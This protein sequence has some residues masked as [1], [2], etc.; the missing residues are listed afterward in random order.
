MAPP[1]GNKGR[2]RTRITCAREAVAAAERARPQNPILAGD[3]RF[4]CVADGKPEEEESD[5]RMTSEL[6]PIKVELRAGGSQ[7]PR[8]SIRPTS[9]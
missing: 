7:P 1:A 5:G 6:G 4:C 2:H 3:R 8:Q 9:N